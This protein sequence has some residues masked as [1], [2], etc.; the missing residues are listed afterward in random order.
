MVEPIDEK[1]T[2][3]LLM[4]PGVT[5]GR[6]EDLAKARN[7]PRDRAREWLG[8]GV[9]SKTIHRETGAKNSKRYV[10]AGDYDAK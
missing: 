7:L 1:F 10:L 4:N 8:K 9:L 5:A 3:L 2:E 6:F